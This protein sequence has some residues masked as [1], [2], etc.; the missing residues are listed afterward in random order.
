MSEYSDNDIISDDLMKLWGDTA[1]AN[2]ADDNINWNDIQGQLQKK[3]EEQE[4]P[5]SRKFL[6]RKPLYWLAIAATLLFFLK[7]TK[8][9]IGSLFWG[10]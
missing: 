9:L 10:P 5:A 6:N 7:A 8:W 1:V 4:I 2:A 3:I